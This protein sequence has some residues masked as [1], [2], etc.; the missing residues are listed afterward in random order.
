MSTPTSAN[1]S[2][3]LSLLLLSAC[4]HQDL[5]PP[6]AGEC[7]NSALTGYDELLII[8]PHPDDEVLGFAGLAAEFMRQGKPVRT[9]VVTD[10]DAYCTACSLWTTGSVNGKTC[11]AATLSNLDT[12]EIDSLAEVRRAESVAA[13]A[14]LGRPAPEFLAYPDT[15]IGFAKANLDAGVPDMLLSRSDFSSCTSC[16]ECSTG[17]GTGPVTA[18]SA[19]T[20]ISSLDRL[21]GESAQNALIATT[22][23]LDSHPDHAALGAFVSDRV[24]AASEERTIAFAVIHA[25]TTNGY[26]SAECWYPGPAAKECACF[27]EERVSADAAWLEA[28]RA[29]RERPDWPQVLP[30]DVDYGEPWQL[31][32]D[33][34]T[35]LAKPRA[36]DA[37]ETQL[38]TAGRAPGIL[39]ES[40]S[41][42]LDCSAYLRSFGRR[43]EVF[44]VKQYPE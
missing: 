35:R 3:L 15:G 43:T 38:G 7:N 31:C 19:N 23:W 24:S 6:V 14:V 40:R 28:L 21:L 27:D 25:N 37:F 44:V 18:L 11:D 30:D 32:L 10:G 42:L 12:P 39:P 29:H 9:V 5:K 36:I 17:F 22:H 20:L 1:F 4:G 8:A 16:G 26:A 34:A 33:D 2:A 13:A 41:G